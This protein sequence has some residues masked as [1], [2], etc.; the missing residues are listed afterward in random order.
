MFDLDGA[1][2]AWR[3]QFARER[4]FATRDLDELEDHL[5]AAYEVELDL[6]P[7]LAP[8]RAFAHAC[9][10]LGTVDTLSREFAK[11]EGKGWRRLLRAGWLVYAIAFFLPVIDGGIT[12]GQGDFHEGL[13]PG[14]Q[15]LLTAFRW[16]GA[17]GIA[18]A[19]TNLVMLATFHRIS[20]AGRDRTWLLTALA[21]AA[22]VF[23]LWW[24]F[25]VGHVSDLYPGYYAW[26]ASFGIAGTGLAMR[27][28]ALPEE[29]TSTE[30]IAEP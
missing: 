16:G 30:L 7:G 14:I 28:R 25:E 26:L 17:F 12:L 15:A 4:S 5:R 22:M 8:A 21:M 24:L 9:E 23:N 3:R 13:L 29:G 27:A 10:T 1:V 20:D 11:V 19:L 18:S 6:S 2:Q